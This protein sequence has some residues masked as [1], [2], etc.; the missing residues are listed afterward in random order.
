MVDALGGVYDVGDYTD[1]NTFD[2][3]PD[4]ARS[5][6]WEFPRVPQANFYPTHVR[7][8]EGVVVAMT[9]SPALVTGSHKNPVTLALP[10]EVEEAVLWYEV[11]DGSWP[12]SVVRRGDQLQLLLWV[13]QGH[14]EGK[15]RFPLTPGQVEALS[16]RPVWQQLWD[17]LFEIC[18]SRDTFDDP[19]TL[20][21]RAQQAIDRICGP[22]LS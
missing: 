7:V 2:Y 12:P 18:Q 11:S 21:G 10:A 4:I 5:Q 14:W 22:G 1:R 3:D 16:S 9:L 8:L 19:A 15:Y 13:P 20:P 6:R 17:A